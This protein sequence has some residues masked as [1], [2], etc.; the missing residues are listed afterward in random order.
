MAMK[1]KTS[2]S[3]RRK[4]IT[5][6][7]LEEWLGQSD[8][9][10]TV[11]SETSVEPLEISDESSNEDERERKRRYKVQC[12]TRRKT[13][14][15][16]VMI[17][18]T[19]LAS[20]VLD[21]A[22]RLNQARE[23]RRR[24]SRTDEMNAIIG[25]VKVA[26][27]DSGIDYDDAVDQYDDTTANTKQQLQSDSDTELEK[28]EHEWRG[29]VSKFL[30]VSLNMF[31]SKTRLIADINQW[32]EEIKRTEIVGG[33]YVQQQK[34][35]AAKIETV[36]KAITKSLSALMSKSRKLKHIASLIMKANKI[37]TSSREKKDGDEGKMDSAGNE[38]ISLP[39]EN[40]MGL[41]KDWALATRKIMFHIDKAAKTS[42]Q[43]N[44]R[45]ELELT[46]KQFNMLIKIIND[47]TK[48]T[49]QVEEKLLEKGKHL[50]SALKKSKTLQSNVKAYASKIE[51]LENEKDSLKKKVT[52]LEGGMRDKTNVGKVSNKIKSPSQRN[53]LTRDVWEKTDETMAEGSKI[54]N[55]KTKSNG[56]KN[57]QKTQGNYDENCKKD[58][59]YLSEQRELATRQQ[60]EKQKNLNEMSTVE[61]KAGKIIDDSPNE[62]KKEVNME[63]TKVLAEKTEVLKSELDGS[64]KEDLKLVKSK[65]KLKGKKELKLRGK[66]ILDDDKEDKEVDKGKLENEVKMPQTAYKKETEGKKE[67]N[68]TSGDIKEMKSLRKLPLIAYEKS[69]EEYQTEKNSFGEKEITSRQILRVTSYEKEIEGRQNKRKSAEDIKRT[70]SRQTLS[71]S[72]HQKR[73]EES[74][75]ENSSQIDMTCLQIQPLTN[76]EKETDGSQGKAESLENIEGETWKRESMTESFTAY[77]KGFEGGNNGNSSQKDAAEMNYL[78]VVPIV[79][80]EQKSEVGQSEDTVR[81]K[82][83]EMKKDPSL[84]ENQQ[85]YFQK[86]LEKEFSEMRKRHN[87][88][89]AW[90]QR[91]V[92]RSTNSRIAKEHARTSMRNDYENE[93]QRQ[94]HYFT[95]EHRRYLAENRKNLTQYQHNIQVIYK[96]SMQL[97]TSV[98]R[99]KKSVVSILERESQRDVALEIKQMESLPIEGTFSS[100]MDT[101][102]VLLTVADHIT[103]LLVSL[104]GKLEKAMLKRRLQVKE[105]S[106]AKQIAIKGFEKQNEKLKRVQES[107]AIREEK[108]KGIEEETNRFTRSHEELRSKLKSLENELE[109]YKRLI[110]S[111]AGR[112]R[113]FDRVNRPNKDDRRRTI[114]DTDDWT[115]RNESYCPSQLKFNL[116][117]DMKQ[118]LNSERE[119]RRRKL[120]KAS[121][122][123]SDKTVQEENLRRLNKAFENDEISS[124]TLEK[125]VNLIKETMDLPRIRFVHLVE[126]YV[127]YNKMNMIIRGLKDALTTYKKNV[128]L[129]C[130]L[131]EMEK[132]TQESSRKWEEKKMELVEN[133]ALVF[134]KLIE[135]FSLLK[136]KTGI[137]L[138]APTNEIFASSKERTRISP[139]CKTPSFSQ[140]I[141]SLIGKPLRPHVQETPTMWQQVEFSDRKEKITVPKIV[142]LDINRWKYTSANMIVKDLKELTSHEVSRAKMEKIKVAYAS[143]YRLPPIASVYPEKLKEPE[144]LA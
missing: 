127:N 74:E 118:S 104:E 56:N 67:N 95:K 141:E 43:D 82:V 94:R 130:Y 7:I 23:R 101:K 138:V 65:T 144:K 54:I 142:D 68:I 111:Q 52:Q 18:R 96:G 120:I 11:G 123:Y 1:R 97:L 91:Q 116:T 12:D 125:V 48:E 143:T 41:M 10:E 70:K 100:D 132:R 33:K 24:Q 114:Y 58:G 49:S 26:L 2:T 122:F 44:V 126:R 77:Q 14:V 15:D 35:R 31:K 119:N 73:I 64:Q 38:M 134:L 22:R 17:F 3:T 140:G 112:M 16:D 42:R 102:N 36:H 92:L 46:K 129:K 45:S 93:L 40:E 75:E 59:L 60:S 55:F 21:V 8:S 121:M 124:E 50:E 27:Q 47:K 103:K 113:L 137:E 4:S 110:T 88:Q 53:M 86:W 79:N 98:N 13:V 139:R 128:K 51:L 115:L 117:R 20:D 32:F 62:P 133:R 6:R 85:Q 78:Q 61:K 136:Q 57:W 80:Y 37:T 87:R 131:S 66:K 34:E 89:E 25:R 106:A 109:A 107:A 39:N 105:A 81:A 63:T 90:V 71:P 28:N 69:F 72:G 83:K 135:E 108:L 76:Y 84:N 9:Q 99:F 30:K 29:E 19:D 5:I